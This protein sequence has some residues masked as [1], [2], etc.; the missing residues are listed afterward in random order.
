MDRLRVGGDGF[1][2]EIYL[3]FKTV[4][5]QR[6]NFLRTASVDDGGFQD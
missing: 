1:F 2:A 5:R 4:D 3:D 6:N